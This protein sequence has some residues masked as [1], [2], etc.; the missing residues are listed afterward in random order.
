MKI[1]ILAFGAHPDDVE[2]CAS[3]TLLRQKALGY[4]IGIIDLTRGELGTRGNAELR[5]KEA[6]N[7]SKI[8]ELDV[9]V[10]LEMADGFFENNKENQLKIVRQIRKFQPDVILAN[11]IRDRHTDHGRAA[12]LVANAA[13]LAGLRKIET[14]VEG[15]EQQAWR[16]KALY[17]YVQDRYIPIDLAVD[18]TD[19]IEKKIKAIMAYESQFYNSDSNEPSTPISSEDFFEFVKARAREFG[20]QIGA[21]FGEGFTVQRYIGVD[22]LMTLK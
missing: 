14:E 12:E 16:P 7:A 17:H 13:F 10:N 4:S 11:A 21:T 18:I 8:M 20:R 15:A 3:G 1:N 9:R 6:E 2:L 22:D 5:S 19:F